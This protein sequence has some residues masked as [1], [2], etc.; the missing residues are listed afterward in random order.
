M[1]ERIDEQISA[2]LDGELAAG[3][4]ELLLK[5][6]E[7][8]PGLRERWGRY[9]LI[10]DTLN[11][12]LPERVDMALADRVMAAIEEEPVWHEPS[13]GRNPLSM[14]LAKPVAG[15]AI[16][17]SVAVVTLAGVESLRN[18]N[19]GQK[20]PAVVAE[21]QRAPTPA[22]SFT[23]V[24]GTRWRAAGPEVQ[25]KLNGYLV[26]HTEYSGSSNLQGMFPYAR[27]AGY[28]VRQR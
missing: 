22:G 1:S 24:S 11:G 23:Y 12:H 18:G 25:A 2:L 17:A 8:D 10:S 14:R 4:S 27:V 19:G 26:N 9:Q 7:R 20:A 28:D 16:A 13:A 21:V 5:R 3:E 6:L 15:L